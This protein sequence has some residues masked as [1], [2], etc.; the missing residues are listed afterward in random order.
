MIFVQTME[1]RTV[2]IPLLYFVQVLLAYLHCLS[3]VFAMS[4]PFS[5]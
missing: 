1:A 5:S 2:V 4:L 3:A